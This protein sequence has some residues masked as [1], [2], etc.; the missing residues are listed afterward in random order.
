L[1]DLNSFKD[2][3]NVRMEEKSAFNKQ[4]MDIY[5]EIKAIEA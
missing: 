1:H 4:K 5:A 2:F 3:M